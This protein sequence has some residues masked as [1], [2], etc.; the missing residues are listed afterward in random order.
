MERT[1]FL[2]GFMGAGKTTLGKEAAK[3]M[4]W[5]FVDLDHFIEAEEGTTI[6]Q[7]FEANGESFF[8]EIERE[9]LRKIARSS[10][11]N[12]IV[13]TGG[14]APC[15]GDNMALINELGISIYLKASVEMLYNRLR[16][17]KDE[18]PMIRAVADENLPGFI[19]NLLEKREPFYQ[20]AHFTL[21]FPHLTSRA[22]VHL[23]QEI[24][25]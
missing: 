21:E 10:G 1:V 22:M 19:Q 7:I 18:R 17:Q 20:K 25:V 3:W 11:K 2:V 12:R 23:I 6:R 16:L 13:A 24:Q 14:G 9:S 5:D 4:G 8:R 15:Y